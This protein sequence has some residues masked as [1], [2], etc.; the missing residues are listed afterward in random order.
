MQ[1]DFLRRN[2]GRGTGLVWLPDGV[3]RTGLPDDVR[4]ISR[5]HALA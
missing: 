5:Q 4:R 3:I 2:T 1:L